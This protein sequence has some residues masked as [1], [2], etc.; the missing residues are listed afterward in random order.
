MPYFTRARVEAPL[1]GYV[2]EFAERYARHCNTWPLLRDPVLALR[3][4]STS[5][6]LRTHARPVHQLLANTITVVSATMC[7]SPYRG[8]T[9]FFFSICEYMGKCSRCRICA[10]HHRTTHVSQHMGGT[11]DRWPWQ[12]RPVCEQLP[13]R[14][15]E[16]GSE[17]TTVSPLAGSKLL[18]VRV[19]EPASA[20]EGRREPARA[21]CVAIA[22]RCEAEDDGRTAC[23]RLAGSV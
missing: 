9:T 10:A 15:W 6:T 17:H 21:G 19:C 4:L 3:L 20:C 18:L 23:E 7:M 1:D 11:E 14:E 16:A 13:L 8:Y 22:P 12:Q 2:G 5:K